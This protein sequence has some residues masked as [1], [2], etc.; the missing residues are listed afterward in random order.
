MG[1]KSSVKAITLVNGIENPR[2]IKAGQVLTI[3]DQN[4]QGN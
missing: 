4:T 3:P 1:I 2:K